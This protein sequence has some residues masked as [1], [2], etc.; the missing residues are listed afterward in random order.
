MEGTAGK[1]HLGKAWHA[2]GPMACTEEREVTK[3]RSHRRAVGEGL[4][5]KWSWHQ[6]AKGLGGNLRTFH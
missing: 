6:K 5:W 1:A 2:E 3:Q 4:E